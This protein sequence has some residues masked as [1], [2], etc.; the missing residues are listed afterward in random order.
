MQHKQL[1]LKKLKI[2]AKHQNWSKQKLKSVRG[3]I[4]N[5]TDEEA[6]NYL[7]E[8]KLLVN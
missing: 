6:E 7:A 5:M 4:I 2:I 1:I 8:I 3:Q